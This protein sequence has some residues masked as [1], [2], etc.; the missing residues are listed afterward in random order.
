MVRDLG[1][2]AVLGLGIALS[3]VPII[4]ILLMILSPKGMRASAG[5]AAG[6]VVGV[7]FAVTVLSYLASLL[8]SLEDA[9]PREVIVL[10]AVGL[11]VLLAVFG[12]VK[13]LRRRRA[14]RSGEDAALPR[15]L[16]IVDN[17][18]RLRALVIGFTYS[19]FRPK[20]LIIAIAA[21]LII[22]RADFGVGGVFGAVA[23]FTG[24]ASLTI[25]G[26]VL[27]VAWGG[28]AARSTAHR[29]RAWLL[30]HIATVTNWALVA[31]G[32]VLITVGVVYA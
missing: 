25:V 10:V 3:P 21:G 15:W 17:F 28:D 2:V 16:A 13:E 23:L 4:A 22:G 18:T 11:G 7:A 32:L 24:V 1:E 20:S 8:P 30:R 26:P 19:A 29:L 9:V 14:N 12:L 27:A 31:F 6:W 5:F